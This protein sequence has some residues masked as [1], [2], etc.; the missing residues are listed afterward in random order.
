M[1]RVVRVLQHPSPHQLRLQGRHETGADVAFPAPTQ[2]AGDNSKPSVV[3]CRMS[4]PR[5]G[6]RISFILADCFLEL[7]FDDIV[8][9]NP[10]AE[11]S[12]NYCDDKNRNYDQD[13][14]GRFHKST[15]NTNIRFSLIGTLAGKMLL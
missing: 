6:L 7:V 14:L 4:R 5:K 8:S 10:L 11:D 15:S 12:R 3:N 1:T 2:P 9:M 13:T